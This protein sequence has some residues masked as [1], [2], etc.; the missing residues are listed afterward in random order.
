MLMLLIVYTDDA[1]SSDTFAE[2][3]FK[4]CPLVSWIPVS[5]ALYFKFF[6]WDFQKG[7]CMALFKDRG[8]AYPDILYALLAV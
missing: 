6:P 8:M 2:V 5:E 1:G 7:Q 4:Y 3:C